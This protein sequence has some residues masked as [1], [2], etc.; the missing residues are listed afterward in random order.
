MAQII[1]LKEHLADW[2]KSKRIYLEYQ[3]PAKCDGLA[4]GVNRRFEPS[5]D[6][7]THA[8][9]G[10]RGEEPDTVTQLVPLDAD[11]QRIIEFSK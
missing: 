2:R 9:I 10:I 8:H 4:C 7:F 11:F 6:A 3:P 1:I 5:A